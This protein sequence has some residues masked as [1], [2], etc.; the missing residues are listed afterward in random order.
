[1]ATLRK[2]VVKHVVV[3]AVLLGG[4]FG[5]FWWHMYGGR[6]AMRDGAG[7][8]PGVQTVVMRVVSAFIL[9]AGPGR[10][11][12]IDAGTASSADAIIGALKA[13]GLGVD[14]VQAIFVTH[15]HRD[16]VGGLVRFP[17]AEVYA[18]AA[19]R[20][21]ILAR[22]GRVTRTVADGEVVT[23]GPLSVRTF[24]VP[25]HTQGSAAFLADDTLFLGDTCSGRSDGTVHHPVWLHT[26]STDQGLE[27]LKALAR[28]LQDEGVPVKAL[29]F[30]H[31]GPIDTSPLER[32]ARPI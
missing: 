7:P 20:D 3:W 8:T 31:S 5:A 4:A 17:N 9:D 15:S 28:R 10:V 13:R 19:E 29:A 26:K 16:H 2:R 6:L 23:I 21:G 32:L 25:G 12:L 14:A 1:M 30:S 18:L 24:A 11:V 22:G 27:S